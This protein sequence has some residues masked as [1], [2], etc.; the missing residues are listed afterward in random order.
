MAE[1]PKTL[2][3]LHKTIRQAKKVSQVGSNSSWFN[4]T[5]KAKYF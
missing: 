3:K 2:H 4:N 5:K 1:Q